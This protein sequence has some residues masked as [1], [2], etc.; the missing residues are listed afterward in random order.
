M[1]INYAA[2]AN[3]TVQ[4]Y[5]NDGLMMYN[6]QLNAVNGKNNIPLNISGYAT[7]NFIVKIAGKEKM[8]TAIFIKE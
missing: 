5:S 1:N 7:G 8:S 2:S 3:E 6:K 4:V